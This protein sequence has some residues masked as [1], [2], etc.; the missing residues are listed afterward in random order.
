M[1]K[2]AREGNVLQ[3]DVAVWQ[4]VLDDGELVV[5]GLVHVGR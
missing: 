5:P 4:E 1:A 3:F 2:P